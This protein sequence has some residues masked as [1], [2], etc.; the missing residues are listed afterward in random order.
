MKNKDWAALVDING[1]TPSPESVAKE[2][3]TMTTPLYI[4]AKKP[5]KD[6]VVTR[7]RLFDWMT[8]ALSEQA[9]GSDGYL[10]ALGLMALPSAQREA[11]RR[12]LTNMAKK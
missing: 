5:T 9:I 6:A 8:Q 11:Q 2:E 10:S 4:I 12:S 3:Y 1:A 7:Q